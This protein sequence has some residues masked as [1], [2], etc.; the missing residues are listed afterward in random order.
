MTDL[1]II[2][3]LSPDEQRLKDDCERRIS[4]GL[5]TW[6]DVCDA[7]Q[8]MRDNRLWRGEFASFDAYCQA[9]LGYGRGR[10][11]QFIAAGEMVEALNHTNVVIPNEAVAR[12]IATQARRLSPDNPK[13]AITQIATTAAAIANL[14][15][16][17][18]TTTIVKEAATK[19]A[20]QYVDTLSAYPEIAADMRR[21][22]IKDLSVIRELNRIRDTTTYAEIVDSGFL[23]AADWHKRASEATLADLRLL[24]DEKRDEH[25]KRASAEADATKG[26][27]EV[28][29]T[30]KIND[31]GYSA[32]M[33]EAM[34]G[35]Q[36][37]VELAQ[38]IIERAKQREVYA[39]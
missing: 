29:L 37:A 1:E 35:E 12:E 2:E 34:F 17:P 31:L 11:D 26:V 32:M 15:Q 16:K 8:T 27:K 23:Q 10:A 4:V 9:R 28:V 21:L 24:L 39:Q 20:Q 3:P 22:G 5:T 30:L 13:Q 7:L 38:Y 25:R 6:L 36:N 18:I 19:H 14:D 33:I